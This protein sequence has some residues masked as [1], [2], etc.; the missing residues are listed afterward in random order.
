MACIAPAGAVRVRA[1]GPPCITVH[2]YMEGMRDSSRETSKLGL[3]SRHAADPS[4]K[5]FGA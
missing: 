3:N 1:R 5:I 2:T 4:T